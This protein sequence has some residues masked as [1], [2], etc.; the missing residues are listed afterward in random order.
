MSQREF[1]P[2]KKDHLQ[3]ELEE[4][5]MVPVLFDRNLNFT[6]DRIER[7]LA[8]HRFPVRVLREWV[9]ES[10]RSKNRSPSITIYPFIA[11]YYANQTQASDC[12]IIKNLGEELVIGLGV[13]EIGCQKFGDFNCIVTTNVFPKLPQNDTFYEW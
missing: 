13:H 7:I 11:A 2:L 1:A 10:R 6:C 4:R 5:G 8:S 12:R 9:Y 3:I